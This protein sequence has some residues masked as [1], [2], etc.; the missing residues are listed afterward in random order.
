MKYEKQTAVDIYNLFAEFLNG[1]NWEDDCKRCSLL[2]TKFLI[3]ENLE[4]E[5]MEGKTLAS[6]FW[7][8]VE[9]EIGLL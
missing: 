7:K 8:E 9:K 3:K 1:D 6:E 2:I 5:E 4:I